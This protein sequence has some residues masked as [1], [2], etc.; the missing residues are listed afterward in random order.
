MNIHKGCV[1]VLLDRKF[2][3]NFPTS[4]LNSK[5]KKK[6]KEK[7][8]GKNEE[9]W[10]NQITSRII[11]LLN[12]V[13]LY[14]SFLRFHFVFCRS[15]GFVRW[16][17]LLIGLVLHQF[18]PSLRLFNLSSRF[19]VR[20]YVKAVITTVSLWSFLSLCLDSLHFLYKF[21]GFSFCQR[22]KYEHVRNCDRNFNQIVQLN[23]II[24]CQYP[25]INMHFLHTVLDIFPMDLIRRIC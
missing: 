16:S 6:K 23:V 25:K 8:K 1:K 13:P 20:D 24:L 2:S 19:F 17:L 10:I 3:L 15:F 22:S 4:A 5:K 12:V 7:R 14:V 9:N 11:L 21:T 18:R